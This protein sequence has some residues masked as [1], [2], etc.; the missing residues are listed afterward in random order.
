MRL[1][2]EELDARL[3]RFVAAMNAHDPD[4]GAAY[5]VGRVNQYYFTGTMQDAL[6]VIQRDG[7]RSLFVRRSY[8]R[9]GLE[10]PLSEVFPMQSYRDAAEKLGKP[11]GRAYAECEI[12]TLGIRARLGKY[13]P[14]EKLCPV[15]PVVAAVRAVKSAYELELM[16]ESGRRHYEFTQTVVPSLLYAGMSEAELTGK[17]FEA[18]MNHGWQGATRFAMFGN[19]VGIGQLGFGE[20]S[21]APTSFDGPG[22]AMPLSS[23]VP[24]GGS[25]D[26]KLKRGDL[27]FVD[28]AFGVDGYHTDRTQVYCFGAS[29]SEEAL[30][31][32]SGCVQLQA[33]IAA[34]LTPGAVPS[35]IYR[36]IMAG[37]DEEFLTH[38]MGF[39]NRKARFL[40]HGIGLQ[41]D[42]L[43][44]LAKG[45]DRPLEEN[46]VFA[47][48]PKRG[49]P[50]VGMVGVE[51]TY[52][53]TSRGGVCLTGGGG[54]I[55]VV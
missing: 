50:G 35:E 51:D 26:R 25:R 24:F 43:P 42:E 38:F 4:W 6:L 18:L 31:W 47:V 36:T 55:L 1:S 11:A 8:E 28:L 54:G 40:G 19:E 41:V 2:K 13:F 48:E 7:T 9:A 20:N 14:T 22:G 32:H 33:E 27:V 39:G 12:M 53:V 16:R 29:P 30:K 34:K 52:V 5:F 37:L 44:V 17:L 49:V 45:F 21:L 15:E 46:M 10:S 23:A 3:K